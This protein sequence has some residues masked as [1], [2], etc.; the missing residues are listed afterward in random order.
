MQTE[1]TISPA[2]ARAVVALCYEYV[3]KGGNIQGITSEAV[4]EA[5]QA[6][7]IADIIVIKE[8]NNQ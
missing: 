3:S 5:G 8:E 7:E 1:V 4:M 6:F 2:A